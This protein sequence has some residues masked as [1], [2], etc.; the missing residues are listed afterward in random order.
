MNA[1]HPKEDTIPGVDA[2]PAARATQ[3][4]PP[5]L[6]LA[7][8]GN[9]TV[10]IDCDGGR[11]SAAAGLVLRPDSDAQRGLTRALAAV[12]AEAREARRLHCTP[13]DLRTQRICHSAAGYE[14]AHE[15]HTWRRAPLC[16]RL[17]ARLPATGAPWA[18]Q[19]TLARCA[20]RV[21]RTA[22]SR[23]ALVLM[24]PCL[25]SSNRPP[26]G[27]VLEAD[28]TEDRAHGA[29]EPRRDD[30]YDGGSCVLPCHL[31][32]G[33]SGRL[34]PTILKATRFSRAH[35]L[36]VRKR[37]GKRLRHA[38]PDTWCLLRGDRHLASPEVMAWSAAQAPLRSVTGLPSNAVWQQ[39]AHEVIEQTTRA[40]ARWGQHATRLHATRSPAGPWSRARRVVSQVAGSDQG[41]NT[42]FVVTDREHTRPQVR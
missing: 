22:I 19:P 23:R 31:Y 33:L 2:M 4:Q 9:K 28:A 13:A 10:A 24:A 40:S 20:H 21:S 32:E 37:V 27:I 18:S 3:P 5:P 42:R 29:Q 15:A 30:G 6:L 1:C 41:G 36:A 25:A 26:A 17:R 12:L 8:V 39:L 34:S 16:T 14:D 11:F 35:R 7:P 38:W